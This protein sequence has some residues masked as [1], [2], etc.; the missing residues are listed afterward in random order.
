MSSQLLEYIRSELKL[1]L[2]QPQTDIQKM[3]NRSTGVSTKNKGVSRIQSNRLKKQMEKRA[4]KAATDLEIEN[5]AKE[6]RTKSQRLFDK[7]AKGPSRAKKA[8][9]KTVD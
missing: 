4:I 7:A 5:M 8:A 6:F 2:E 9:R 3:I 1:V